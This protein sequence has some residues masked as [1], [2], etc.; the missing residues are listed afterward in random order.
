MAELDIPVDEILTLV[1]HDKGDLCA[2]KHCRKPH[3]PNRR[4]CAKC[5]QHVWRVRNPCRAAWHQI[6]DRA[7]RKKIPFK[8][9]FSEFLQIAEA[10]GYIES[11][12][13]KADQLHLD[14]IDVHKG[15]TLENVRVI[16][17]EEN[18]RKGS[19]ERRIQLGD[20]RWVCLHEIGIGVPC[21]EDPEEDDWI[22]PDSFSNDINFNDTEDVDPDDPDYV[23]F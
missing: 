4:L 1:E 23:P 9:T 20:G 10:T 13:R 2:T 8:L 14:R 22:D 21:P 7:T 18:S 19:Y 17:C 3:L 16:T 11:K 5:K 6:K 12:G 15:Y